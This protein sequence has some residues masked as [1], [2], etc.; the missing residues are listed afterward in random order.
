[1]FRNPLLLT[2]LVVTG[3]IAIAGLIDPAGVA[4][5]ASRIVREQF[6]SRGWFIMLVAS[7]LLIGAIGLALSPL[8]RIRLGADD[9]RPEFGTVSWL[10]ML[11]AAGMGVGLLFYGAAEPITHFTTFR[12]AA[13]DGVVAADAQLATYFHW[14]LHAW[15]IY[16]M[17]GLVI[18]Y[19]TFRRGGAM[20]L[21]APITGVLGDVRWTRALGF[22]IDVCA[23]VAIAIG[24]AGSLAL[25]VFQVQEGLARLLGMTDAGALTLPLFAALC[26]AFLLPL[27][28]DLSRGMALMSNTA[29]AIAAALLVYL[30][31]V[32]PTFYV[33]N[34]LTEG[35]GHYLFSA[36]PHG[37]TVFSFYGEEVANWFRD[38]TLNYMIWWLAWS[39]FVGVFIARISR[40]RTIREFLLF[41]I[42]VPTTFSILWFGTFGALGFAEILGGNDRLVGVTRDAFDS[43]TFVVLETLPLG[44]VTSAAVVIA[45]FLFVIT[46]VVSAAY[47]LAMFAERGS[48]DPSVRVKLIWGGILAALGL[49]MLLSGDVGAVRSIIAAGAI[50]FVFIVPLLMLCLAKALTLETPK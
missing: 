4:A 34:T 32:G 40:G 26:V 48:L 20:V 10:T 39:P 2:A 7:F 29:M 22:A 14:G 13:P 19:F 24:V 44:F 37:F 15:A 3:A 18:A 45:C 27:T 9:E 35:F 31:L 38:W 43:V 25:G 8:G 16:A 1:M 46:S 47:V 6:T 12:A 17:V 30:L 49:V 50:V 41:V 28:V 21:S 23:I 5:V 33:M 36:L 42:G 11:F